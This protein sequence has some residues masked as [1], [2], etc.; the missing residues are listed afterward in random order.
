VL[1]AT[2]GHEP[3]GS[4]VVIDTDMNLTTPEFRAVV[5]VLAR[6][7]PPSFAALDQLQA[8]GG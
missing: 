8:E 1:N 4:V 2:S 7:L 6:V 3:E 5:G